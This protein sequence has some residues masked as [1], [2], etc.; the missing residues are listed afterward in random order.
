MKMRCA[1][2]AA[3]AAILA[4]PAGA[5]A[6]ELDIKGV[7]CGGHEW[8]TIRAAA[9]VGID[10]RFHPSLGLGAR[11]VDL[12]GQVLARDW[13]FGHMK[14]EVHRGPGVSHNHFCLRGSAGD[15]PELIKDSAAR[16]RYLLDR[17]L[18][19]P[20]DRQVD[21][22]DGGIIDDRHARAFARFAL[23][24]AA[25]HTLQDSFAHAHRT[26]TAG[27]AVNDEHAFRTS[28]LYL[29]IQ[30]AVMVP[31]PAAGTLKHNAVYTEADGSPQKSDHIFNATACQLKRA[32]GPADLQPHAFAALLASRD[33][34]LVF[35]A[36]A[37][38]DESWPQQLDAFMA[39]WFTDAEGHFPGYGREYGLCAGRQGCKR[40]IIPGEPG[41]VPLK[42]TGDKVA[43]GAKDF[44]KSAKSKI[45]GH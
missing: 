41:Y 5:I 31:E 12:G 35:K 25:L 22:L 29:R 3:L 16:I 23:L 18:E 14:E 32:L 37:S 28:G 19:T 24:G 11:Y 39:H 30:Q 17:A 33:F 45:T 43:K 44:A 13:L 9:D 2:A 7:N 1:T 20:A 10:P 27:K 26:P 38:G 40:P 6:F 4:A 21:L 15:L 8:L 42:S 36:A 34:L